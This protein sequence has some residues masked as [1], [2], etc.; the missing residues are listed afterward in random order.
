M[1]ISLRAASYGSVISSEVLSASTTADAV[2]TPP[3]R[4]RTALITVGANPIRFR[5]DSSSPSASVGHYVAANGNLEVYRNEMS[6]IR[7]RSTTSTS[8]MFITYYGE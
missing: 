2:L 4:A 5:S 8:D 6:Q 1:G 7:F 3:A